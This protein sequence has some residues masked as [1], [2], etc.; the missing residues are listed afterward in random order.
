VAR[1]VALNRL[2]KELGPDLGPKTMRT[3]VGQ[4]GSYTSGQLITSFSDM[5]RSYELFV[6]GRPE[7]IRGT[8]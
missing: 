5:K 1:L 2:A 7:A 6:D 4:V 3:V 8:S